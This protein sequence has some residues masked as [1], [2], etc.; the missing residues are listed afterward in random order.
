MKKVFVLFALSTVV[1]VIN[2]HAQVAASKDTIYISGGTFAGGENAG[3]LEATINGDTAADGTRINPKRVYGL[4]EGQVYYQSAPINVYDP[5][6]VLTIAGVPD[7]SRPT[8]RSKPIILVKSKVGG[9]VAIDNNAVNCLYGSLRMVNIQYQTMQMNGYQNNELF[10]CGTANKL[11]QSLTIDSCLF[12]F[13]NIDLFDCTNESGAIGGWPYGARFF[14]TNSYFRNMFNASQWWGSRVFQC[15]HPIDTL[16]VENTTVVGGGLTFL[17]QNALLDFGYFNHNTIVNNKKDWL[18]SPYHRELFVTNNIF[19]NQNWAGEDTNE[20]ALEDPVER[21][22]YSTINVD[23]LTYVNGAPVLPARY[24]SNTAALAPDKMQIYVSDNVNYY[25]PLLITGYYNTTPGA[26]D[27]SAYPLSYLRWYYPGV[28]R[29]ENIPCE[30]MNPRTLRLFTMYGPPAG[31]FIERHTST[32]NPGTQT[33]GIIDASVVEQMAKWNQYQYDDPKYPQSA[34]DILHSKYIFGDYSPTTLPGVVNGVNTDTITSLA[35]LAA[36]DQLGIAK[37]TNLSENFRQ[38]SVISTIDGYP[39]GSLLWDDVNDSAYAAHHSGE[40]AIV[41]A[42]YVVTGSPVAVQQTKGVPGGFRL[43]QN[44]PNPF[45]PSTKIE[46][47]LPRGAK[48]VLR[49]YDIL[50]R[51]IT[52]LVNENL[53]AGNY[54]V[55]FDARNLPSGEY[56]YRFSAEGYSSARMMLLLK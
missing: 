16:W 4:F 7:P 26:I 54:S 50:G 23:T 2:L 39:V 38:N 15:K 33:P 8:V 32:A 19:I 29:V 22:F 9:T 51:E 30:W 36:G 17:Q 40:W 11:P 37:F 1:A 47:S 24:A 52:A 20:V 18:L 34:N 31:G 48:V 55:G 49:V 27:S 45:N 35:Q 3:A 14:I 6:G 44:Y 42:S 46:F 56:I 53:A 13:C 43:G 25:D 5:S 21:Q 41:Y 12:E 28:Y 10:Y